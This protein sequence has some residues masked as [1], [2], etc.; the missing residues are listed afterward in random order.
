MLG[1]ELGSADGKNDGIIEGLSEIEGERDGGMIG[2]FEG[3][4]EI[5]G[6]LVTVGEK[7]GGVVKT[8]I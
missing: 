1:E 7:L 4:D 3:S 2:C 5:L 6:I 8:K